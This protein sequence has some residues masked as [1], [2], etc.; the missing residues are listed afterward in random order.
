VVSQ[1]LVE[2]WRLKSHIAKGRPFE[3]SE[4]IVEFSFDSILSA[5]TGLGTEQGDVQ[6]QLSFLNRMELD[7]DDEL[8]KA[9][10]KKPVMIPSAGRSAKLAALSVDEES[11]WKGFYM[12]W[13]RLYHRINK[14]RPSVRDA[15]RTLRGYIESRIVK[16][17]PN[18]AR[19]CQPESALDHVIQREIKA[20][21]KAGRTPD[22]QDLNRLADMAH[23]QA[24][25]SPR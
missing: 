4:D 16:A 12:P 1:S 21:A 24:Y 13:P 2:L 14:L 19:G 6:R 17:A 20:A 22:L 3:A 9:P 10:C 8:I 18:L 7:E 25:V 5:A 11:L 23:A 15:G